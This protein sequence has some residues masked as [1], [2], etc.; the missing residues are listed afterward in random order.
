[1]E[2]AW[3]EL[4][5]SKWSPSSTASLNS[6]WLYRILSWLFRFPACSSL[7]NNSQSTIASFFFLSTT[8]FWFFL[9]TLHE[10]A[11]KQGLCSAI[12]WIQTPSFFSDLLLYTLCSKKVRLKVS[13]VVRA[14]VSCLRELVSG[15]TWSSA[16]CLIRK[17]GLSGPKFPPW[18]CGHGN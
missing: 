10:S 7:F 14:L 13:W 9:C 17:F 3:Q 11:L 4:T 1:M 8:G 2:P 15:V 12:A 6:K 18:T 5:C 16:H